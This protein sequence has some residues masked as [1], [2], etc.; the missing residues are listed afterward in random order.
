[1]CEYNNQFSENTCRNVPV[2]SSICN[3]TITTNFIGYMYF[4]KEF[5]N[6]FHCNNSTVV[7]FSYGNH[8][9]NN[10]YNNRP[11]VNDPELHKKLFNNNNNNNNNNNDSFCEHYR[12]KIR[13]NNFFCNIFWIST[14]AR[15]L[16]HHA[17][18][19]FARIKNYNL[20]MRNFFES[21]ECTKNI[22]YIDVYNMTGCFCC[23]W[24]FF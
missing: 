2:K 16:G 19:S 18:E 10:D 23:S 14:H 22:N 20:K 5:L 12:N 13:N 9:V 7:L 21:D 6:T 8:P 3:N 11:G 24:L 17:D 4:K 15:K 1:M